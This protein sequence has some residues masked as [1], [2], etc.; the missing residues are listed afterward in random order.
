M[1]FH[2]TMRQGISPRFSSLRSWKLGDY[3]SSLGHSD[4][5]I[6]IIVHQRFRAYACCYSLSVAP[7]LSRFS[8]VEWHCRFL[9]VTIQYFN[10]VVCENNVISMWCLHVPWH[11]TTKSSKQWDMYEN[12]NFTIRGQDHRVQ[13]FFND[14]H[15]H[16]CTPS[17]Y[18]SSSF[19]FWLRIDDNKDLFDTVMWIIVDTFRKRRLT[20][21][22]GVGRA[23][24]WWSRFYKQ[25]L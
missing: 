5:I 16:Q 22:I 18:L 1:R 15:F 21:G 9:V 11:H 6:G 17:T 20:L 4:R 7:I 13:C 10:S 14:H 23:W 19:T 12:A 25:G 24:Y 3:A 2:L 8:S